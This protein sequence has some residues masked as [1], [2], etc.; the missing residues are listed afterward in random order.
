MQRFF[1]DVQLPRG[2]SAPTTLG[3]GELTPLPSVLDRCIRFFPFPTPPGTSEQAVIALRRSLPERV[4]TEQLLHNVFS[5][6][7]FQVPAVEKSMVFGELLPSLYDAR[8]ASPPCALSHQ[9]RSDSPRGFAL[10]YALLAKGV[11]LDAGNSAR[12]S[13]ATTFARLSLA[14]LG[15]VSIFEKPSYMAALALL[16]HSVY[17]LLRHK[18]LGD[19]GRCFNNMALQVGL[20]VRD[21][22]ASTVRDSN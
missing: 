20:Q 8:L 18:E 13:H 15:A 5:D 17:H 22:V 11:L 21:G 14:G 12:E 3:F 1:G 10:L 2:A 19:R 6:L 9:E 4:Y 16:I 7:M